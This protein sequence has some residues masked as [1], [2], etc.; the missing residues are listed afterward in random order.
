MKI[1]VKEHEFLIRQATENDVPTIL[2]FIRELAAYENALD[3]VYAT[4]PSLQDS[5][6]RTKSAEVVLG[7]YKGQPV[8]FALFFHNYSTWRGKA[9]LYLEDLYVIPEIR[10]KGLGKLLLSYLAKLA[11]DR[12]CPR[13]EW[14][15]LDWNEPAIEFYR[16]LGAEALEEW[17]V[18]RLSGENLERLAAKSH[19]V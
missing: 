10:G 17:T 12:G 11:L 16:G 19:Q 6:F 1:K 5:L 15:C 8:G 14:S 4:E 3:Q 18:Y 7:E 2:R 13:F 9:G